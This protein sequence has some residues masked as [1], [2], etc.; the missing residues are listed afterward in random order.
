V[1][2]NSSNKIIGDSDIE[3][4]A[5]P[6]GAVDDKPRIN[7]ETKPVAV[8]ASEYLKQKNPNS[9][10]TVLD[11]ESDETIIIKMISRSRVFL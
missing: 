10:V 6:A 2:V 1:F 5:Y 8:E 3:C 11:R 9:E 4:A 7:R